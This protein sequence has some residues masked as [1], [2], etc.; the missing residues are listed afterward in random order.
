MSGSLGLAYAQYHIVIE[1]INK[2]LLYSTGNHTQYSAINYM[3]IKPGKCIY[4]YA[5]PNH[6]DVHLGHSV[7]LTLYSSIKQ[8]TL[9]NKN[10]PGKNA[11]CLTSA[12]MFFPFKKY[13]FF[14]A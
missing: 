7:V 10:M 14:E 6:S 8:K 13:I 2:D 3:G 5:C 11:R 1:L 12:Q 9:K 4:E